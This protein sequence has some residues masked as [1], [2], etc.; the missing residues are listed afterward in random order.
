[1]PAVLAAPPLRRFAGPSARNIRDASNRRATDRPAR[2]RT[3][4]CGDQLQ[5]FLRII[6]P[7]FEFRSQ[8]LRRNLCRHAYVR[9]ARIRRHKLHFIDPNRRSLAVTERVFNLLH[10]ILS[11]GSTHGKGANQAGKIVNRHSLGKLNTGQTSRGK[12]LSKTAF[13]LSG[14]ERDSI[15]QQSVLRHAQQKPGV[16]FFRQ[17][18]L[19]LVPRNFE[20]PLRAL[21]LKTVKPHVLHQD[22]EAMNKGASRR[23]PVFSLGCGGGR[24]TS[25]LKV[26]Y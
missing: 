19:Q 10:H 17:S 9:R 20:L 6:Q 23:V 25:L 2:A 16:A 7:F 15:Q 22:V 4:R 14:L 13:R 3:F 18:V 1:M 24:N 12:K 11:L 5:K 26:R 8:S 21:M